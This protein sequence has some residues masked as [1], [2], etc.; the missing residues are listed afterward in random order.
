ML[1]VSFYSYKGGAGRSTTSW[2]TIQ[3]LVE[4]MDPTVEKPFVIVDTDTESA[5]STFLYRAEKIF[6]K[7][8]KIQS[9]QKRIKRG[10]NENYDYSDED[11]KREFFKGM[12]PIGT[13]FG[14]DAERNEAVLFI[15]ADLDKSS[16]QD[17]YDLDLLGKITTACEHYG[18]KAL[19]FDT[20]SGTQDLARQS[21][22]ES[23]IIVCCMRPTN[24]FR[25]GTIRQLIDFIEKDLEE[26]SVGDRK[27]ILTPTAICVDADQRFIFG[28]KERI[29]PKK[30]K[31]DIKIEFGTENGTEEMQ[32][33]SDRFKQAFK[34]N[35]ILDMLE[36]T[37]AD[38]KIYP[39]SE[40]NDTVF[41]IPEIKRFKWFETCLGRLKD[42]LLPN[43]KMGINRYEYLAQTILKYYEGTY[44][45]RAKI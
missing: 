42:E 10:G 44:V 17:T 8:K 13:L 5:G 22:H 26:G 4:L 9:I 11:E 2:N 45:K 31:D 32:E 40:D 38:I 27:Y 14:L 19:F 21:I 39:D 33:K 16:R 1:Q 23:T 6:L 24:Q 15:G 28:G 12:W 18:A 34:D 37:P 25:D 3:R 41:G 20:P 36:P 30:A 43:D 7:N 29:Y 35:V